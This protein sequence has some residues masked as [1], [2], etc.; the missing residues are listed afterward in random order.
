MLE[1]NS[2]ANKS[3]LLASQWHPTKNEN[4]TLHDVVTGSHKKVWRSCNKGY[5][6]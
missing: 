3:P 6:W 5:E 2:L 4:L 1:L